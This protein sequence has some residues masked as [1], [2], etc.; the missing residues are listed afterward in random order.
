MEPQKRPEF[1]DG[2]DNGSDDFDVDFI[3]DQTPQFYWTQDKDEIRRAFIFDKIADPQ[4]AGHI[5]VENMEM[6][7]QWL[8][9]GSVPKAKKSHLKVAE[10]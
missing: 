5:L 1:A 4:I 6:I 7:F 8:T 10:S 3:P 9:K 2:D